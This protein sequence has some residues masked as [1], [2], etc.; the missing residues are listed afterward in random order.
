[1]RQRSRMACVAVFMFGLGSM[2]QPMAAGDVQRGQ[3]L[4]TK[5]ATCHG[6]QGKGAGSTPA[7]AGMPADSF[8]AALAAYKSGA[9]K[10][11]MMANITKNMSDAD[12]A[13]LA[14][15]YATK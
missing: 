13:D 4:A 15:Y 1:M 3:Q 14:A 10:H 12:M 5:C 11:P 8:V 9:R 7:I 6:P 2:S